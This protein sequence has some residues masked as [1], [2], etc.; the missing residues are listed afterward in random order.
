[1]DIFTLEQNVL[2]QIDKLLHL[3]V[4]IVLVYT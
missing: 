3:L 1:M 2:E 4:H